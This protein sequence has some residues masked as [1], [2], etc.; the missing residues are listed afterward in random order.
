[1]KPRISLITLGVR[2]LKR[3]VRF[4]RD[5]LGWTT[6]AGEDDP[7]AFFQLNGI[8]L[9][10]YGRSDL[11]KDAM[12]SPRG[13]GFRGVTLAHNLGSRREV[14]RTFAHLKKVGAKIVKPPRKADW[15]GY[16]GYFSDPD[17][18][19]WEV[20]YNPGWKLDAQGTV[21]LP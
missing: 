10:L 13:S 4:Y 3:S 15:G 14:D 7:V 16:S 12:T 17:G 11:A 1:M 8:V 6:S 2:D 18:H 9:G 21:A 5:G 19:L 20:A